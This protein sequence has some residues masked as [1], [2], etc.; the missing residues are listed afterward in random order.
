MFDVVKPQRPVLIRR[1][2]DV[3][4]T[5]SLEATKLIKTSLEI[6]VEQVQDAMPECKVSCSGNG[7]NL[8]LYDDVH[9]VPKH[10]VLI[11]SCIEF[12]VAV[13]NWPVKEKHLI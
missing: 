13:Y 12:T 7:V 9:S 8:E 4:T 6:V 1:S 3:C 11:H 5:S 10:A 2:E